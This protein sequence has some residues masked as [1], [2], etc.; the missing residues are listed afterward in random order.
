MGYLSFAFVRFVRCLDTLRISV[1]LER[2]YVVISCH[3]RHI[4]F[5]P[6]LHA[7]LFFFFLPSLD[8]DLSTATMGLA[9][10]RP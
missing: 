4:S 5:G 9:D 8:L 2:L 3:L 1:L 7:S 10:A 6:Q